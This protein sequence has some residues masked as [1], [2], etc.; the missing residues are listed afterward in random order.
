MH[1]EVSE[2]NP[3]FKTFDRLRKDEWYTTFKAAIIASMKL[4]ISEYD[5][6][7]VE[8]TDTKTTD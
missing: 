7:D 6:L 2:Y 4:F 3:I 5:I 1:I 8:T